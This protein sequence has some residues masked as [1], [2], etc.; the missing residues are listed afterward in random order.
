MSDK[1]DYSSMS[2]EEL[3]QWALDDFFAGG[4]KDSAQFLA[5]LAQVKATQEQ[6]QLLSKNLKDLR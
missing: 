4:A 5:L 2:S 6:T 3:A 1:Q